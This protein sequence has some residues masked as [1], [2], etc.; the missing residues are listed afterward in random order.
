LTVGVRYWDKKAWISYLKDDV[1]PFYESLHAMLNLWNKINEIAHG[2]YLSDVIKNVPSLKL[3][4]VAGTSPPDKYEENGLALVYKSLFGTSLKLREYYFLESLGK[5]LKTACTVEKT[6]IINYLDHMSVLFERI[7][8][9]A[10]KLQLVTEAELQKV[11]EISN[12]S[13]QEVLAKPDS[14]S[15]KFV[16]LLNKA[17]RLTINYNEYTRFIWHLRKIPKKYIR[18]FYP[19]LLK[20]EV[21]KFIQDFL[22]LTEYIVPQVEDPEITDMYT[23]FSF[24]YATRTAYG[25]EV[26]GT[27][28]G[29]GYYLQGGLPSEYEPYETVGGCICRINEL[30]WGL[31]GWCKEP[32]R[33]V[34]S[35]EVPN[36]LIEWRKVTESKL[37]RGTIYY[38]LDHLNSYEN[39]SML[40]ECLPAIFMGMAELVKGEGGT[41]YILRRW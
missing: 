12:K 39:L 20:T 6:N 28:V 37:S 41:L 4:F 9:H 14:I 26:N 36:P 23:I 31:F 27:K 5:D 19:E 18:E 8:S 38:R 3:I 17:L 32:L 34:I 2:K 7:L 35:G 16:E 40:D 29:A 15:E 22:G 33:L 25:S 24:D 13:A 21:F 30:I 11:Q 1:F 10:C